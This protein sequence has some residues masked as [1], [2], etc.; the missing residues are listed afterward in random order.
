VDKDFLGVGISKEL[1]WAYYESAIKESMKAI[2]LTRRGE[3]VMRPDF[4]CGINDMVFNSVDSYTLSIMKENIVQ[5]LSRWE[6][7]IKNVEI[8]INFKDSTLEINIRYMV[9]ETNNSDNLVLPF[10]PEGRWS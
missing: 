6:P 1:G 3:R 8:Q 5:A 7:R 2:L 9:I 10:Y 4:G